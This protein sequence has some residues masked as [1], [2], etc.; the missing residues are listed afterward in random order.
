VARE[1]FQDAVPPAED[2]AAEIVATPD[3][4]A[5][6]LLGLVVTIRRLLS[7][8]ATY[9]PPLHD[10]PPIACGSVPARNNYA[11]RQAGRAKLS[12]RPLGGRPPVNAEI[13]ALVCTMAPR[14]SALGAPQNPWRASQASPRWRGSMVTDCTVLFRLDSRDE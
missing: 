14:Q 9:V 4:A 7:S 2:V 5:A 3:E 6:R 13:I 11:I 10:W 8:S 1:E 12:R